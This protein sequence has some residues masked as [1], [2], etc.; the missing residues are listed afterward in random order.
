M[1]LS[2]KIGISSSGTNLYY[3]IKYKWSEEDKCMIPYFDKAV[4]MFKMIQA[5]KNSTD[6]NAIVQRA[7]AGDVSVLNVKNGSYADISDM[8]DNLNDMHSVNTEA[9]NSFAK[10]DPNIQVLFDNDYNKFAEA[11]ENGTY[12]NII[13][14]A[15]LNKNSKQV[16]EKESEK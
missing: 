4:D 10:L 11:V 14:Q 16:E 2:D 1:T 7:A 13:N 12:V 5:S 6:I 8:P 3:K 15:I 9:L